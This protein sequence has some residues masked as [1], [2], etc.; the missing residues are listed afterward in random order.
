MLRGAGQPCCSLSYIQSRQIKCLGV[1]LR[2]IYADLEEEGVMATA[3]AD[4]APGGS[5]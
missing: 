2:S 4:E 5:C 3:V 1:L